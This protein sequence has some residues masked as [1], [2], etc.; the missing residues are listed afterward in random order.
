MLIGLFGFRA[1][2]AVII[3]KAVSLVVVASAL[4]FRA[5][6]GSLSLVVSLPTML[7][8]FRRYSRDQSFEVIRSERRFLILMAAGSLAGAFVGAQLLGVVPA[9]LLLPMLAGILVISAV[10]V[11]R[12]A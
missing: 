2:P 4:P 1:L 5:V 11:W 7:V 10:K 8:G 3:N 12:H 9:Q 6:A